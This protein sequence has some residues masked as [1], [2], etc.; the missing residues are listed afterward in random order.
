MLHREKISVPKYLSLYTHNNYL[1]VRFVNLRTRG[2]FEQLLVTFKGEFPHA[3]WD[4]EQE[5][6]KLMM[7]D[8]GQVKVF[9]YT[10]F[11]YD[12]IE[13]RRRNVS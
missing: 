1:F 2:D 4:D 8:A 12:A 13:Y 10:Y 7:K 11:G 3:G 5:A 6:W 9:A